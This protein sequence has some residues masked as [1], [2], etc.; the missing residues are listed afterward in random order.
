MRGPAGRRHLEVDTRL[1]ATFQ[2]VPVSAEG[3][4]A[5]CTTQ[6]A[7]VGFTNHDMDQAREAMR[8]LEWR[9]ARGD[10]EAAQRLKAAQME[11]SSQNWERIIRICEGR[12]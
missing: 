2:V 12:S 7:L 10:E 3:A 9:A 6:E 4:G 5:A 11:V 1:V 8:F